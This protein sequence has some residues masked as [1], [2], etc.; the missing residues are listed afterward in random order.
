AWKLYEQGR[1]IELV[2]ESINPN[3]YDKEEVKKIIEI[4][5]LC[6]QASATM[7][8]AMSKV[9]ILLSSN[10]KGLF[11][12][13]QPSMPTFIESTLKAPEDDIFAT[14]NNSSTPTNSTVSGR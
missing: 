7:R 6:T 10:N 12:N 11:E 14:N 9:V 3:E 8:P 13:I 2:D 5:L 4:A 1:H